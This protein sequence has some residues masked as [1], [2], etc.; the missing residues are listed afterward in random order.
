MTKNWMTAKANHSK[1][2]Q[3]FKDAVKR[4]VRGKARLASVI[5]THNA[6]IKKRESWKND[7]IEKLAKRKQEVVDTKGKMD[8][9]AAVLK[10]NQEI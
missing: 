2:I 8:A 1:S 10:A 6:E 9:A 4:V 5:K 7:A 3:A